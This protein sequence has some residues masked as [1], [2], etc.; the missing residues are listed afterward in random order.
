MQTLAPRSVLPVLVMSVVFV[1]PARAHESWLEAVD[2]GV[3]WKVG[4]GFSGALKPFVPTRIASFVGVSPDGGVGALVVPD[5]GREVFVP[6]QGLT[7]LAL[8]SQPSTITLSGEA[9]TQYLEEDGLDDVV[10]WRADAGLTKREGRERYRRAMKVVLSGP[11]VRMG[12]PLE[13]T[14]PS[15]PLS[16]WGPLDVTLRW[17]GAPLPGRLVR[18]W[19][20]H[21]GTLVVMSARTG[22][23]GR[24]SFE[25]P[26]PGRWM[27]SAVHMERAA[28]DAGA[29]DW[30]ST[31][32][33]MTFDV[34]PGSQP[35]RSR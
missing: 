3:S 5:G 12:Q 21:L 30:E 18:A 20:H 29:I 35:A 13:L 31:W 19:N 22:P 33:S 6:P 26:W 27:L 32:A 28:P 25:V 9:F 17:K 4:E 34:T 2:G 23:D 16:A 11:D 15:L 10:A 8:D 7:A 14:S 1:P 24:V